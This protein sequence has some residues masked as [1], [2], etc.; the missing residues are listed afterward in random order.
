MTATTDDPLLRAVRDYRAAGEADRA[1]R[2]AE[3]R[4]KRR[5]AVADAA[6]NIMWSLPA[7]V[8]HALV[9]VCELPPDIPATAGLVAVRFAVRPGRPLDL[10][11]Q[12][13]SDDTAS[14][15]GWRAERQ[16]FPLAEWAAALSACYPTEVPF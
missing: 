2:L 8:R 1:K 9:M 6:Q 15:A 10:L 7:D 14:A 11:V 16:S 4:E 13:A 3:W 5:S 12:L